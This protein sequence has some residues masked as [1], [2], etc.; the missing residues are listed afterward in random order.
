MVRQ[1]RLTF[2]GRFT[3]GFRVSTDQETYARSG[4]RCSMVG[5]FNT[6]SKVTHQDG[7]I[8][9][10]GPDGVDVSLTPEAALVTAARLEAEAMDS[11]LERGTTTV[12]TR[13]RK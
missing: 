7:E 6:P 10:E 13:T 4:V 11:L 2:D 12:Q 1:V 3:E 8:V 5:P 9:V